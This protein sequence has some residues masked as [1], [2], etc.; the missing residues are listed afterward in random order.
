MKESSEC[1]ICLESCNE[2]I[3][4]CS[5]SC[6]HSKCLAIWQIH[7]KNNSCCFCNVMYPDW[8]YILRPNYDTYKNKYI[9]VCIYFSY[10]SLILM[11][12]NE[13]TKIYDLLS[14]IGK[15]K[16]ECKYD[17]IKFICSF[18]DK[19]DNMT[20]NILEFDTFLFC[21]R[22]SEVEDQRT[23]LYR[24]MKPKCYCILY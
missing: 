19:C 20:L 4:N 12:V 8:K 14:F 6:V 11:N 13:N 24:I 21:A 7:S 15:Y 16:S 18:P 17:D 3:C 22:V 23:Y 1:W 2:K 9:N 10:D 5:L